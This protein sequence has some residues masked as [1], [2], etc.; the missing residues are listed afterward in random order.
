MYDKNKEFKFTYHK[1][2]KHKYQIQKI[3][4]KYSNF[5]V[6]LNV[7]RQRVVST[8]PMQKTILQ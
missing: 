2:K 3:D 5:I 4:L 1:I 8:I 7:L 6:N